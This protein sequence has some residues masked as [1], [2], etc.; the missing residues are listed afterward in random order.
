MLCLGKILIKKTEVGR[1]LYW[2]DFLHFQ[3]PVREL[4]G[5]Q[6]SNQSS[7]DDLVHCILVYP[8][9]LVSITLSHTP[10]CNDLPFRY[11]TRQRFRC[12]F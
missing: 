5:R 4:Q 6:N 2:V 11:R 12:A 10:K 3:L 7:T 8:I 1:G 9:S